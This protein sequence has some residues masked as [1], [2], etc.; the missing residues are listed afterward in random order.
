LHN[1]AKSVLVKLFAGFVQAGH[2]VDAFLELQIS[3]DGESGRVFQ[4]C[5]HFR[6]KL[7]ARA[8]LVSKQVDQ[9]ATGVKK[10]GRFELNI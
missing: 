7:F 6:S 9:R 10:V 5:L 4:L 3:Q 1:E 8:S 2:F